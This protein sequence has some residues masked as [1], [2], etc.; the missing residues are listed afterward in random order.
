MTPQAIEQVVTGVLHK[1]RNET[2]YK[3][4]MEQ[5]AKVWPNYEDDAEQE[6]LTN[7]LRREGYRDDEIERFGPRDVRFAYG[8]LRAE[9]KLSQRRPTRPQEISLDTSDGVSEGASPTEYTLE[10]MQTLTNE[11]LDEE[12]NAVLRAPRD[13]GE[14]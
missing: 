2:E 12:I 7:F 4:E 11:Q 8:R 3:Q 9:E 14:D 10:R 1:Q 6:R 5:L 13:Y